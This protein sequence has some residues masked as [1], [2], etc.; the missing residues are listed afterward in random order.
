MPTLTIALPSL[1]RSSVKSDNPRQLTLGTAG[2]IDHG[3]SAL[4]EALTGVNTDQLDEERRRGMSIVLGYA[5]L[6]L[7]DDRA[8]SVIDV[9]GHERFV[10]TMVAG[11]TGVDLFLLAVAADDGVMPQ[12]R[13]HL[14]VLRALG[15]ERGVVALTKIDLASSATRE[16]AAEEARTLVPLEP[17]PVS[18]RTGEGLKKLRAALA[19]V[20]GEVV[21]RTEPV[22]PRQPAVLH[23]DRVFTLRGVGTVA[24][25]TLWSGLIRVG[26]RLE[27]LPRGRQARVRSIQ[28]HGESV[29]EAGGG[30]RVALNLVGINRSALAPGDVIVSPDSDLRPSYRLDVELQ[31]ESPLGLPS[32]K[33]VQI[34]HG[35]RETPARVVALTDDGLAQLR[36]EKT[37]IARPGDRVVVRNIAP[38][39]TLG[40]GI[41]LDAAPLR[42]GPGPASARLR[43][44]RRR[45]LTSVLEEEADASQ[46]RAS[47]PPAHSGRVGQPA[48]VILA[49]LESD[50][51]EPRAPGAIAEALGIEGRAVLASLR[52]L[53]EESMVLQL[54]PKVF[55]TKA[56][57]EPLRE[58]ATELARE[59]GELT[60]AELRTA[61]GTSRKYAQALLDHLDTLAITVRH[62][63]HHVLR[64]PCDPGRRPPTLY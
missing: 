55:Y 59:R 57:L 34:H 61:L 56:H 31:L 30:G 14:A 27:V 12:T 60:V 1:V 15:V 63:D 13:E 11:A 26:D 28:M 64:R 20:A 62:G 46:T 29:S 19:R 43:A 17:V 36:L 52:E 21:A 39:V 16:L 6:L 32:G 3:K 50:G 42:H 44:I 54:G 25:G 9:P 8:L 49:L 40:G 7:S 37:L 5:R 2:H 45:G 48:R 4:V 24:T 38:P 22:D 53:V 18:A 41:V 51:A 58:V 47:R 35:T 10:R 33:R 23:I